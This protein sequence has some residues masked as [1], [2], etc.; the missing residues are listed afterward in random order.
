MQEKTK[1]E[2]Q[3]DFTSRP[4][5]VRD[6][7]NGLENVPVCLHESINDSASITSSFQVTFIQTLPNTLCLSENGLKGGGAWGGVSMSINYIKAIHVF[8]YI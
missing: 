8:H 6:I 7:S 2:G 1:H 4:H 3:S 5:C